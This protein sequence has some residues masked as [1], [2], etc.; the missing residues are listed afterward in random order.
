M[1]GKT[2]KIKVSSL[3]YATG[4]WGGALRLWCCDQGGKLRRP[5]LWMTILNS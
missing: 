3:L 4:R 1:H 2:V 5:G